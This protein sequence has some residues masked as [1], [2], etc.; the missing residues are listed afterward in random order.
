MT[1]INIDSLMER[2]HNE[3]MDIEKNPDRLELHAYYTK[4]LEEERAKNV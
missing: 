2:A 4:L 3:F 1:D